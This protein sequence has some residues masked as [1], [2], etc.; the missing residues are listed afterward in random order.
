LEESRA[1]ESLWVA[2]R[3][4]LSAV[5]S[6]LTDDAVAVLSP[7][8]GDSARMPRTGW[9][10]GARRLFAGSFVSHLLKKRLPSSTRQLT[11]WPSSFS[12]YAW[13]GERA[14]FST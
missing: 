10:W 7:Q 4:V 5:S 13:G 3:T 8:S 6:R 12:S 2:R 14:S 1:I 9:G 11:S